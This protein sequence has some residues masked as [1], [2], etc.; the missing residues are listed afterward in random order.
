VSEELLGIIK[1]AF[2]RAGPDLGKYALVFTRSRVIVTKFQK[3]A[4][5]LWDLQEHDKPTEFEGVTFDQ[6]MRDHPKT[7]R[8]ISYLDITKVEVSKPPLTPKIRIYTSKHHK[9]DYFFEILPEDF[10]DCLNVLRT[11][12]SKVTEIK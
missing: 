1:Y 11:I 5:E 3:I 12:F 9:K 8:E 4:C 10:Q 2:V 6:L 7:T